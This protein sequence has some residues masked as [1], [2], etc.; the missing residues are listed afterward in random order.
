MYFIAILSISYYVFHFKLSNHLSDYN[1]KPE[2]I[3]ID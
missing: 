1:K 2:Q 3:L